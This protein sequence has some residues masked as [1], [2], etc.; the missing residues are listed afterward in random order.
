MGTIEDLYRQ[1]RELA[2]LGGEVKRLAVDAAVPLTE[3]AACRLQMA[4]MISRHLAEEAT[5]AVR[6]L[7]ASA[8]AADRELA[9]D[10]S[11]GMLTFRE[12]TSSHQA[13]WNGL[14]IVADRRGYS[15]AVQEQLDWLAQRITW[16]ERVFLP[17]AK[18]LS[19][20]AVRLAG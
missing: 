11:A 19:I 14:A 6:P 18:A 10:Y 16:E 1:H 20:A 13:R 2:R 9:R 17:A 8:S 12:T 7:S 4:Q 5:L 15:L 3:L